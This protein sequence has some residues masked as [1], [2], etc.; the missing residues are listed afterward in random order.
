MR[1]ATKTATVFAAALFAF[2]LGACDRG[3]T[4][5]QHKLVTTGGEHSVPLYSDENT[6][7]QVSRMKQQGGVEGMAGDVSKHLSAR[8]IDDQT[9]VKVVSSD[10]NGAVVEITEG[11]M[12][13]QSGFVATGNLD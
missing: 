8:E 10:P 12:K 2:G 1:F 9:H 13:G 5:L 6:Y 4:L 11:P 3:E 7:M